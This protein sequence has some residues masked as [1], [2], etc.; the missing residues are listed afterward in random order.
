MKFQRIILLVCTT[1][2]ISQTNKVYFKIYY[3]VKILKYE[4]RLQDEKRDGYLVFFY[5][6]DGKL[7]RKDIIL[8]EKRTD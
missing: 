8:K 6:M 4:G 3:V 7:L 5:N 2:C 1:A